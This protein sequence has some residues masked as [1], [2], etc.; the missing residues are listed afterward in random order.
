[1]AYNAKGAISKA[2]KI[3]LQINDKLGHPLYKVNKNHA[4]WEKNKIAIGALSISSGTKGIIASLVGTRN[5]E[6]TLT[7]SHYQK[8]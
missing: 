1:L 5:N 7:F 6:S 2:S 4:F 8:V 3:L